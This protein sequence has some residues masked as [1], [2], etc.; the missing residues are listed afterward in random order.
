MNWIEKLKVRW[1]L[2]NGWQVAVILLVFACTGFTVMYTK[3]W[4]AFQLGFDGETPFWH[5]LLLNLGVVLPL[6]QVIL[7]GYGWIFGQFRFFWNFEKK[8]F[9]RINSFFFRAKS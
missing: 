9:K 3:R 7:L 2:Q 8:L 5:N 4:L 1:Q 6:Y